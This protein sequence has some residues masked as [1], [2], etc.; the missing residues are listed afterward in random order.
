MK[1]PTITEQLQSIAAS[2][3]FEADSGDLTQAWEAAGAGIEAVEPV[4]RFMEDHPEI[5]FG[6]PGSLA[7]FIERFY[8]KGY[9]AKLVESIERKPTTHTIWML[10]RVI[11][12]AKE[13]ALRQHYVDLLKRAGQHPL[14][15]E[16]TRLEVEDFLLGL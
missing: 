9:E 16:D 12:G 8:R 10:H 6:S 13:P 14:A 5:D 11:N 7:H 3:Y 1:T 15:D 2:D 4:L